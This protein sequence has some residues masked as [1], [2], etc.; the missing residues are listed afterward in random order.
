MFHGVFVFLLILS[1]PLNRLILKFILRRRHRAEEYPQH[2]FLPN[3]AHQFVH[4]AIHGNKDEQNDLDGPEMRQ[5][6]SANNF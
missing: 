4:R 5:M 2:F 6:I 3:Y 1:G